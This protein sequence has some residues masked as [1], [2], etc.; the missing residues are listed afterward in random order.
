MAGVTLSS[1]PEFNTLITALGCM[2]ACVQAAT[3]FYAAVY[4]KKIALLKKNEILFRSHRAF[5]GFATTLYLLGLFNGLTGFLGAILFNEPPLELGSTSFNIHTWL[6]FP[7]MV[8]T[9]WKTYISYFKKRQVYKRGKIL[10]ILTFFAWCFTWISSAFSYYLRTLDSYQFPEARHPDPTILLPASLFWLQ[11][12][13]PFII[14][15]IIS[16]FVIRAAVK[17]KRKNQKTKEI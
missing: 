13:L 1:V 9:L 10:G 5:G 4:K 15:G 14:G 17:Y 8:V 2:C 6:S 3:G 7:V 12:I 11:L 16:L